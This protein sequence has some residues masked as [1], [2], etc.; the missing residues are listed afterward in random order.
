MDFIQLYNI[1]NKLACEKHLNEKTSIGKVAVAL[2]AENNQVF[3]GI[4][5]KTTC[6]LGFCAETAAIASMLQANQTKI[7]KLVAVYEDGNIISPC[8]H[9]RELIYQI[10]HDNLNC[11]IKLNNKITTLKKLLPEL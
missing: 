9:C 3:T 4:C 2:L 8:G 1:A 5:L 10:N 6:A 11:E 7:L